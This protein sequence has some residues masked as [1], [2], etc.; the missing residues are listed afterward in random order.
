MPGQGTF[1][2]IIGG[3]DGYTYSLVFAVDMY[4]TV[5]T[6]AQLDPVLGRLYRDDMDSL[7]RASP[8]MD[9]PDAWILG[10]EPDP[11]AF[12]NEIEQDGNGDAAQVLNL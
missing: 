7:K 11:K 3:Y 4:T 8:I 5:F 6:K 12:M 2:H 9:R 10:W 1:G